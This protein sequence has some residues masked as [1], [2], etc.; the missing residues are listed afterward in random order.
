MKILGKHERVITLK[1]YVQKKIMM[2]S[3]RLQQYIGCYIYGA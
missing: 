2:V 1:T 3:L